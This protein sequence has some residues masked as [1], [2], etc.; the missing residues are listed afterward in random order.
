ME[1][2]RRSIGFVAVPFIALGTAWGMGACL[3]ETPQERDPAVLGDYDDGDPEHRPGQPCLLCHGPGHLLRAPGE[4]RLAIA[5]TVYGVIDDD[6]DNGLQGVDV[7]ITD[8]TGFEFAATTNRAGNFMFRI[9]TGANG[10]EDK[11][12]GEF[13]L[14]REPT[15]PLEVR[16]ERGND[17]REMKTKIWREGSCAHCHGPAPSADSVGRVY[18]FDEVNP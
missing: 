9:D 3:V 15:Y 16:I 14:P 17:R 2:L 1:I 13:D 7:I 4:T 18:L 6:E 5:G 11:G 10:V 8:A 12:D